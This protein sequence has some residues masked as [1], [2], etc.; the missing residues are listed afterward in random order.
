M[1]SDV[2]RT[3]AK[4]L[5]RL[6]DNKG[7]HYTYRDHPLRASVTSIINAGIPKPALLPWG[8]RTLAEWVHDHETDIHQARTTGNRDDFVKWLKTKPY[9]LRDEAANI[10]TALHD[11]AE[12]HILGETPPTPIDPVVANMSRQFFDF[13]DKMQ[14]EYRAA[15]VVVHNTTENYAG[16]LDA[17]LVINGVP[18]VADYKTGK[19]VYGDAALQVAALAACDLAILDRST[20]IDARRIFDGVGAGYVIHIRPDKWAVYVVDDFTKPYAA[21][22]YAHAVARWRWNEEDSALQL[23]YSGGVDV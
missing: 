3:A 7:R 17:V 22:R 9:D 16:T 11:F 8:L 18:G 21:F 19:G 1:R 12:A 5:Q 13:V 14:P 20:S 6:Q 23:M 4:D 10:G 15:E 2:V